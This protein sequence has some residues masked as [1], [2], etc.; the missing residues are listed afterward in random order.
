M[1]EALRANR[2]LWDERARAHFT[3]A[4]YDVDGFRRGAGRLDPLELDEIGLKGELLM[5]FSLA[6]RKA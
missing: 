4:F 1:D 6:A 3:S 5:S 2:R